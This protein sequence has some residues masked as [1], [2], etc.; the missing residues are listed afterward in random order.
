LLQETACQALC[1]TQGLMRNRRAARHVIFEEVTTKSKDFSML[2]EM[3]DFY[4]P[5]QHKT[6]NFSFLSVY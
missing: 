4:I 3:L 5:V 1:S 2:G 6:E